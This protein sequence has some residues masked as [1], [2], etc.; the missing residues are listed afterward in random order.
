MTEKER[1][2]LFS[3]IMNPCIPYRVHWETVGILKDMG[4]FTAPA[5]SHHHGNYEG[6]LFDHCFAVT[7][8]LVSFTERLELKW[9][10]PGSPLIVGM[11]HDLCKVDEYKIEITKEGKVNFG[12]EDVVGEEVEIEKKDTIIKGH[13]EK[14][15][16]Y[17]SQFLTL[18]EEEILCIRFHMGAYN[19]EDWNSYDQA[20]KQFETVLWTHTADMYA[21]KVKNT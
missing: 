3:E 1:I 12:E 17:L 21:S 19:T 6:G 7:K 18:T 15:I 2:E 14:S 11:F 4:Y 13:G 20:I 9:S 10:K 5:S 16:I 8:S